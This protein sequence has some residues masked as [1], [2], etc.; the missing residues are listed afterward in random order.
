MHE[1]PHDPCRGDSRSGTSYGEPTSQRRGPERPIGFCRTQP[2]RHATVVKRDGV[3]FHRDCIPPP[4]ACPQVSAP[5]VRPA[6]WRAPELT[7]AFPADVD[8]ARLPSTF[9]QVTALRPKAEMVDSS[10][11]FWIPPP[12]TR[13]GPRPAF[14]QVRGPLS[15]WGQV[16]DSN[17]RSFRDG[18]TDQRRQALEQRKRRFHRQLTCA[19]PTDTRPPSAT[20]GHPDGQR[21]RQRRTR[22][23]PQRLPRQCTRVRPVRCQAQG[24]VRYTYFSDNR[25][26][27]LACPDAGR[28]KCSVQFVGSKPNNILQAKRLECSIEQHSLGETPASDDLRQAR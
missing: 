19:F 3:G 9:A 8:P 4:P 5:A 11:P 28:P 10:N 23:L 13:E 17:L 26:T 21:L 6:G 25:T 7:G 24:R 2:P 18:F 12:G 1:R 16:K 14:P 22:S 20:A 27:C 15:T